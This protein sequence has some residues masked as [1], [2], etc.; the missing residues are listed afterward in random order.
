MGVDLIE[1][2]ELST[3]DTSRLGDKSFVDD[4]DFAN[5]T[6]VGNVLSFGRKAKKQRQ[7]TQAEVTARFVIPE[8]K[9]NDCKWL[10]QQLNLAQNE[11]ES[12]TS[13]RKI[14][15]QRR[16]GSLNALNSAIASLKNAIVKADCVVKKEQEQAEKSKQEIVTAISQEAKA[17]DL[18]TQQ[19]LAQTGAGQGTGMSKTMKYALIGVGGLVVVVGL[20]ALLRRK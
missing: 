18:A 1:N 12:V 16:F 17:T 2:S 19:A 8:D 13:G 7:Q 3:F 15:R 10:D 4:N 6:F 9:K 11:L 5:Y 14:A 20:V